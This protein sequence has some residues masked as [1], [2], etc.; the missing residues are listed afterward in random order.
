MW[1]NKTCA[2]KTTIP[3]RVSF[4]ALAMKFDNK[5]SLWQTLC[6][7]RDVALTSL[8]IW[9]YCWRHGIINRAILMVSSTIRWGR[10]HDVVIN[11]AI[12]YYDRDGVMPSSSTVRFWWYHQQYDTTIG[13]ASWC[14]HHHRR[15][16]ESVLSVTSVFILVFRP[17]DLTGY[18]LDFHS[19]ADN[20]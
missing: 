3:T 5:Y 8:T 16:H 11:R 1:E 20:C 19:S 15:R 6:S 4:A 7:W 18:H 9:N 12:R 14:R 13:T 2:L 10:R 17:F